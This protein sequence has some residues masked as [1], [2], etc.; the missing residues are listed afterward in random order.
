MKNK[1]G[2]ERY[3]CI[4]GKPGR[5]MAGRVRS[6]EGEKER[7]RKERELLRSTSLKDLIKK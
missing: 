5:L 1:A 3:K 4:E 2:Y 7:R 6:A